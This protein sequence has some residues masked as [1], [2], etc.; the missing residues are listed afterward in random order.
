[1]YL[2]YLTKN[3]VDFPVLFNYDVEVVLTYIS[4]EL[5]I[6]K[7]EEWM[8]VLIQIVHDALAYKLEKHKSRKERHKIQRQGYR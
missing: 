4:R 8:T 7:T 2:F 6:F 1:M 5:L 3:I